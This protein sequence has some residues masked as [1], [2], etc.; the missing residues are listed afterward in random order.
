MELATTEDQLGNV[1][2]FVMSPRGPVSLYP[3][4]A[5]MLAA[6]LYAISDQPLIPTPLRGTERPELGAID[7]AIPSV[8]PATAVA[9]VT[10]A[11]AVTFLCAM[12]ME[13]GL[14]KRHAVASAWVLGL[15]TGLWSV[16]ADQL[17][18]HGPAT[19]WMALALW[20]GA[21]HSYLTAGLAFGLA[22]ATR[23]ITAIILA[24]TV[25]ALALSRQE[26]GKAVR[27]GVG[28]IPGVAFLF[29][30]NWWVFGILSIRGGYADRF[31]GRL[32][33]SSLISYLENIGLGLFHPLRGLLVMSPFIPVLLMGARRAWRTSTAFER[34]STLGAVLYLLFIWRAE[35]FAGGAGF[36]SY[37]YPLEALIALVPLMVRS[38]TGFVL[39]R[40]RWFRFA[41]RAGVVAIVLHLPS[42]HP[43]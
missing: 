19:M 24:S 6:P 23:P 7:T 4:G 11:L 17:W 38:L 1:G 22:V 40:P 39:E 26:L 12:A 18:Q 34:G 28:A 2:W 30:Y 31:D 20:A 42:I 27:L 21:R 10:T 33:D 5:P 8:V 9:V 14:S 29:A 32:V 25:I 16:A 43:F 36:W 3:P 13:L 37:R 41:I 15:G 35:Q